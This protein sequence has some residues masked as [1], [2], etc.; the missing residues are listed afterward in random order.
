[1]PPVAYL[2]D[3]DH[4]NIIFNLI[5]DAIAPL[6]YP[7]SRLAREFFA[8]RWARVLAERLYPLKDPVNVL[9]R[10]RPQILGDG[11]SE[12]EFI[13]CHAPSGH[14]AGPHN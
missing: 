10:D 4:Q 9:V 14:Q 13:T 5:Q 2:D 3:S 12:D 1:M 7:V 11:P 6:P 8:S